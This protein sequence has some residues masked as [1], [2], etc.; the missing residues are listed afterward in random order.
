M[1]SRLGRESRVGGADQ[2][3]KDDA[4]QEREKRRGRNRS[5]EK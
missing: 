1:C 4:R 2:N 3:K 5:D